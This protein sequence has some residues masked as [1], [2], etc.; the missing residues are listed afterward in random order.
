MCVN[1]TGVFKSQALRHI[2]TIDVR[3]IGL[4]LLVKCWAKASDISDI[5]DPTNG[6][7]RTQGTFVTT[8][9][10]FVIT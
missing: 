5:S 2:S 10:K 1:N 9:G 7:S 3:F 8:R 4:I 6:N